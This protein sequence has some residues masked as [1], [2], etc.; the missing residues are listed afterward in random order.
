MEEKGE[1]VPPQP[2]KVLMV[3]AALLFAIREI[4]EDFGKRFYTVRMWGTGWAAFSGKQPH[5]LSSL[6]ITRC[7]IQSCGSLVGSTLGMCA[8]GLKPIVRGT[9][10]RLYLQ[11]ED[12]LVTEISKLLFKLRKISGF[13]H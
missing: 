13:K 7:L 8:V 6:A 11:G 2:R 10:W 12:R 3:D 5:W 4:M 9:V 1:R